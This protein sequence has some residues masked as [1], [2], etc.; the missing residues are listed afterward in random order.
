MAIKLEKLVLPS[1]PEI[2]ALAQTELLSLAKE[3]RERLEYYQ[4][5]LFR[6]RKK[7]FGKSSEKS[8]KTSPTPEGPSG[9]PDQDPKPRGDT[10]KQLSE[11]YPD[12]PVKEETIGFSEPPCCPECGNAMQ[13]SG[14]TEDCEYLTTEPKEY[15]IVRQKR[16]KHRCHKCH[17]TIA[18]APAPARVIPGGS[19]SDELIVD[20]TLSKYCDLIPLERYCQMAA[21]N[22]LVGLPPHSLI[23]ASMKLSAFLHGVYLRIRQETL[24]VKVLLADETPH[25]MLE[26]DA[27]T[28][29]YLWGF[30]S[31]TS[32]FFECHDTRS[33]DVSTTVLAASTCEFLLTDVYRGYGKSVRLANEIRAKKDLPAILAAY[34]NA[35]AR[36][37][38]KDRDSEDVC[39]DAEIMVNH[40]KAIYKLNKEAKGQSPEIILKKRSEMRPIFE[41]MKKE[42]LLKISTYSSKSQMATA[43]NYFLENYVGLTRFL[44]N[45]LIPIDNNH[46][47]RL[48]RSHVIGR[49]T[50]YGTHS[51]RSAETASIHFTVVES[52]KMIGVNP[53][54]FYLDAVQRIHTKSPTIT[55]FEYK[56]LID[57]NTC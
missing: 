15:I 10:T 20:A 35:H 21:R 56:Q 23:A 5:V 28:R 9:N 45:H 25:R 46:S 32:C 2:E 30:S 11:R 51:K 26:G 4:G 47:E 33:G 43:Y 18:T 50:W 53:R 6:A 55:P 22:G 41:A 36:R 40:Y 57:S 1:V 24:N 8:P 44:D 54:N 17:S 39:E 7:Q 38:F 13:D 29:W 31:G 27:K 42:A 48:L 16:K 37:K 3:W 34:C 52:C 14:M 49:K 19:Y 12:A